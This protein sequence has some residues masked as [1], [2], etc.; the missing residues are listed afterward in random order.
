MHEFMVHGWVQIVFAYDVTIQCHCLV[1]NTNIPGWFHNLWNL[2]GNFNACPS[3]MGL[4]WRQW[5]SSACSGLALWW[6]H[7]IRFCECIRSA[8]GF[9]TLQVLLDLVSFKLSSIIKIHQAIPI[10]NSLDLFCTCRS[11]VDCDDDDDDDGGDTADEPVQVS[12]TLSQLESFHSLATRGDRELSSYAINGKDKKRIR[13]AVDH[14]SCTCG[15]FVPFKLVLQICTAF[16]SLSKTAQDSILWML[17]TTGGDRRKR[18]YSLEGW[19]IV[20]CEKL[21][22]YVLPD[23]LQ[24]LPRSLVEALG[25]R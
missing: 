21:S 4:W 18:Y 20:Q 15:C 5:R 12:L 13:K 8:S 3:S 17:Q 10:W 24:C 22:C 14:P 6:N 7:W 1:T 25:N 2:V 9:N 11:S 16:W 23:R 19:E